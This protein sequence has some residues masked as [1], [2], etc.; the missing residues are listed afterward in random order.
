M[1]KTQ[2]VVTNSV[3]FVEKAAM[4]FLRRNKHLELAE[5]AK[6]PAAQIT[7]IFPKNY[8]CSTESYIRMTD[9]LPEFENAEQQRGSE[10]GIS[11]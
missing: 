4:G 1:A 11:D 5:N 3:K 9:N 10:R 8:S 7:D 2:A 6:S